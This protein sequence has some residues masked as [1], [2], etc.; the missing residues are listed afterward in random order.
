MPRQAAASGSGRAGGRPGRRPGPARLLLAAALALTGGNAQAAGEVYLDAY[1]EL[2]RM[3]TN[4][5]ALVGVGWSGIALKGPAEDVTQRDLGALRSKAA[6]L[7]RGHYLAPPAFYRPLAGPDVTQAFPFLAT[8]RAERGGLFLCVPGAYTTDGQPVYR[9]SFDLEVPLLWEQFADLREALALMR[10]TLRGGSS[11][12]RNLDCGWTALGEANARE[13][14]G[15]WGRHSWAYARER[16]EAAYAAQSA[17]CAEGKEPWWATRGRRTEGW[18]EG[19]QYAASILVRQAYYRVRN[20]P[21]LPHQGRLYVYALEPPG[22]QAAAVRREWDNRPG[23]SGLRPGEWVAVGEPSEL[24]AATECVSARV[25][26]LEPQPEPWCAEPPDPAALG[27]RDLESTRGWWAPYAALVL[28]WPQ[29]Y[30]PELPAPAAPDE[31]ADGLVETGCE[32]RDC[33]PRADPAWRNLLSDPQASFPLGVSSGVTNGG[34]RVKAYVTEYLAGGAPRQMFSLDTRATV[35]SDP[36]GRWKFATVK[37]P[38][39]A[40]VVF[41]LRGAWAGRPTNSQADYRLR[42]RDGDYELWFAGE[43]PVVHVFGSNGQLRAVGVVLAGRELRVSGSANAW[44]GLTVTRK[45]LWELTSVL[46]PRLRAYPSYTNGLMAA[47]EYRD[48]REQP[49]SRAEL[50]S[51][52]RVLVERDAAGATN[53]LTHWTADGAQCRWEDYDGAGGLLR[54]RERVRTAVERG[55]ELCETVT[56]GA[57]SHSERWRCRNY[58]WGLEAV[59][60]QQGEEWTR[61]RYETNAAAEGAWGQRVGEERSDGSWR[62]WAYDAAGRL[63]RETQPAGNAG[64]EAPEEQCRVRELWYAGDPRLAALGFPAEPELPNDRRP[65]AQIERVGS[66]EVA[67]AYWAYLADRTIRRRCARSDERFD[68]AEGLVELTAF[69][70]NGPFAGRPRWQRQEDGR[71]RLWSYV[72]DAGQRQLTVREQAGAGDETGVWDGEETETVSDEAGATLSVRRR[73]LLSGLTT[74]WTVYERDGLGRPLIVS[75]RLDGTFRA[76]AY[77][78]CGPELEQDAEGVATRHSYDALGRLTAA[79]R[80]QRSE[81]YTYDS[82]DQVA[83]RWVCPDGEPAVC[84]RTQ[85]DAAGRVLAQSDALG[86]E[87]RWSYGTNDA[88]GRVVTVTQPDGGTRIESYYRDGRLWSVGGTA[89]APACYEYGADEEGEFTVAYAGADTNAAQWV[90]THRD[91]LGRV[92]RVVYADGHEERWSY[93]ALGRETRRSD[94]FVTRLT[95]YNAR[96]DAWRRAVDLDGDGAIGLEGADRVTETETRCEVVAGRPCAVTVTRTY[97]TAGSAAA[98]AVETR[99]AALDGTESWTV[100]AGRTNRTLIGRARAAAARSL[101]AI[102]AD[103]TRVVEL[104]TNGLLMAVE[105]RDGAGGLVALERREYDNAGR[106]I[107]LHR[108]APNGAERVERYGYD[109]AGRLTNLTLAADGREETTRFDYDP[110][111][112]RVRTVRPDGGVVEQR[113]GPRGELLEQSGA[114][115]YPVRYGYDALGRLSELRTYRQGAHGPADV[116]R[117]EYDARRGWLGAKEYADGRRV[118]YAYAGNGALRSRTWAR[119]VVTRYAYDAGGALTNRTYSDGTPA[120]SYALDREGRVVELRAGAGVWTNRY[121]EGGELAEVVWSAGER[122]QYERDAFGRLTNM[123]LRSPGSGCEFAVSYAYDGAGRL[124]AVSSPGC[125]AAYAYGADGVT[126][127]GLTVGA[128]LTVTRRFDGFGRLA[129]VC[130]TPAGGAPIAFRYAYNAAGQRVTNALADGGRWVY[131]Y[132]ALGQVVA[133]RRLAA[134][135]GPVRGGLFGYAYDS[136]GNRLAAEREGERVTYTA[137]A[138]NQ[139][140]ALASAGAPGEE[141]PLFAGTLFLF[142]GAARRSETG[143]RAFTYD[144]DGNLLSDGRWTYTWDAENRLVGVSDGLTSVS[145]AYDHLGRRVLSSCR[146]ADGA[147]VTRA[148]VYDGWNPICEVS[149][150]PTLTNCH[151]YC[152]GLDV[153]GTLVGAGG[154][155]GLLC[156]GSGGTASVPSVFFCYDANGNVM[157]LVSTTGAVVAE[158]EYGPFGEALQAAGPAAALNPWRFST[159]YTEAETG[160]VMYPMRPYS[161]TLGRFLSRDPIEE[162]GGINLY[163]FVR[164]APPNAV[165]ALGLALYAFDGTWNDYRKMKRPTNV[166][167]L[168]QVYRGERAYLKGVGTDWYT[169]HIGGMTGAG[170]GNR[171]EDMYAA[172]VRIYNT[173]DPTGENQQIDVIGFSRG[174]ALARTFVNYINSKGG[175][176]LTGPDGRPTGVVCPV[177]IRFLGIFDTVASFGWPGND[178]NWGQNLAIPPNVENVRHAVALDEKRGMFPL[179]S[180]LSDPNNP[181]ADPRIVEQGFRGAHSDIGG[182]YEDGDRSN[183][184]LMWMRDEG[185]SVGV[186]FGPL[187]PEDIGASNPIIHDERGWRERRRDRPRE[188]YYPNAGR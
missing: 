101:T 178:V 140:T 183:F 148:F 57:S 179:S 117:W 100:A 92:A 156:A 159:R 146:G 34:V 62:R 167:K 157:A 29:L 175:V 123:S 52:S 168:R 37:R 4:R 68:A 80:L 105:R 69:Y 51:G 64:P 111:G 44:P 184:A 9:D 49:L 172:L 122:V 186:P 147:I 155:G 67:R 87:T 16:A 165:D 2:V 32:C 70:T 75:N 174:A 73:D 23:T 38:K 158:Y 7:M 88:G 181:F 177:K 161:P 106:L 83:A 31:A 6:E 15:P 53:R 119:G 94:G 26:A 59:E 35:Q 164:N 11:P 66:Q 72:Y 21:A 25:G 86:A 22:L 135:G 14:H 131:E 142:D 19:D 144:A 24:S 47:V 77:G 102:G 39:G 89:A 129:E 99:Y 65:R 27:L 185:V 1:N 20:V 128:A 61:W 10:W 114:G 12:P 112:R 124:C 45:G 176:P 126:V 118:S 107:G 139:Y 116:T 166:W 46:S 97:P 55:W 162:Q 60:R 84:E 152:W 76:A 108:T 151:T 169:R 104:Y 33:A 136:I 121:A 85:S 81:A 56:A 30:T 145:N 109:A 98:R 133:G 120:V 18:T 95:E 127:T 182:G 171:I 149:R 115:L 58:P 160:L 154:I 141:R 143:A 91:R 110:M 180:V 42:E 113:Y 43:R 71:W 188:I 54:R 103:G 150:T 36:G 187:A 3:L 63:R 138:L 40:E 74:A 132:D 93:D 90:R 5:C 41:A 153:S 50:R 79:R 82:R 13:G 137:N 8:A 134:D 170:G 173:P 78:C 163:A 17:F 125:A 48:S 130:S 96:G 28:E